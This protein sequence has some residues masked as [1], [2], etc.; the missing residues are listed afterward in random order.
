MPRN[1]SSTTLSSNTLIDK[2][3]FEKNIHH[4]KH[5]KSRIFVSKL[6]YIF[7]KR[8]TSPKLINNTVFLLKKPFTSKEDLR[9][10]SLKLFL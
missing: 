6:K 3:E 5:I 9:L 7:G 1:Q 2:S 8:S 10:I 4:L